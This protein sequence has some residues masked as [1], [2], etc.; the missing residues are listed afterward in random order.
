[1][2]KSVL[3]SSK[4]CMPTTKPVAQPFDWIT[5]LWLSISSELCVTC[6]YKHILMFRMKILVCR[7][8]YYNATNARVVFGIHLGCIR[9]MY[10][11]PPICGASWMTLPCWFEITTAFPHENYLQKILSIHMQ[12]STNKKCNFIL[13]ICKETWNYKKQ[14]W[15]WISL[16]NWN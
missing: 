3:T 9:F 12:E 5:S 15:F 10:C 14:R 1:M 4:T 7:N 8:K 2:Q 16:Q 6:L 13:G 11:L